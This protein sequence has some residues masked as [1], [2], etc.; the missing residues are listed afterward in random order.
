MDVGGADVAGVG[1]AVGE[2]AADD[3]GVATVREAA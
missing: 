1:A 2:G 3:D